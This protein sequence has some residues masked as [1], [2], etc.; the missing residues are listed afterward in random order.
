MPIRD[1]LGTLLMRSRMCDD[2]V[3]MLY[4]M[5][6][7]HIAFFDGNA[8]YGDYKR[9]HERWINLIQGAGLQFRYVTDRMLR[10]GEFDAARCTEES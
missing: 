5:P 3:A 7:T 10:L 9:D 6:S 8:T 2:G 4:S 1:G